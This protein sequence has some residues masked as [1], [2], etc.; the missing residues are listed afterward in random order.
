MPVVPRSR[1]KRVSIGEE[2]S[3]EWAVF[4]GRA[5]DMEGESE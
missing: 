1:R 2:G 5:R 4:E 3:G